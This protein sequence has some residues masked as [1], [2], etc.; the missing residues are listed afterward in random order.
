MSSDKYSDGQITLKKQTN[1]KLQLVLSKRS[2][3]TI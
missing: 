3:N 1:Y 2:Y